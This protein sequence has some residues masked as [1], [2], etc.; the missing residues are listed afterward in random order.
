M[1]TQQIVERYSQKIQLKKN[2]VQKMKFD[3]FNLMAGDQL[4]FTHSQKEVC[5]CA[6]KQ[7][8]KQ[9]F[10][11]LK[12]EGKNTKQIFANY[13]QKEIQIQKSQNE[14]T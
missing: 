2:E 3:L 5:E 14:T 9:G 8:E 11:N 6:K 7:A 10:K 12:I 4:I 1:A 13:I